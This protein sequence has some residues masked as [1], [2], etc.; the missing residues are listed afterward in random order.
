MFVVRKY[1]PCSAP[2]EALVDALIRLIMEGDNQN[3]GF[4]LNPCTQ[5]SSPNRRRTYRKSHTHT[6]DTNS[7]VRN[8]KS[9]ESDE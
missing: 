6:S 8:K 2:K 9:L 5:H 1:K 3:L 4:S 7:L